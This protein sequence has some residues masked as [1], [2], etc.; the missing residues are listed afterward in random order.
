[1]KIVYCVSGTYNSGGIERVIMTKANYLAEVMGYEVI[2]ITSQQRER[3]SFYSFSSKI[4]FYDLG[5]NYDLDLDCNLFVRLYRRW[6]KK[7]K[8][9]RLLT[10]Y[11][12]E[13]RPDISIS[14]FELSSSFLYKIED[15]SRKVLECHFCKQE[16]FIASSNFFINSLQYIR[17]FYGRNRLASHYD[18]FVVLTEEDKSA[19]G[20]LSNIRVIPNA[21]TNIPY[22]KAA[23]KNKYVLSIG[24]ISYQKGFDRLISAWALVAPNFPDWKLIIRGNGDSNDLL[25]LV[26]KLGISESVEIKPATSQIADEYL[27]SSVYVMSSRYEGFGMV[28]VE[29]MSYGLPVVSFDCPCGP[30]ELISSEYGS[31]VPNGNIN[32]LASALMRWMR[33]ESGRRIAGAR[34][35]EAA[36]QYVQDKVMDKWVA[37]FEVLLS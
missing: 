27:K 2:I 35:R 9:K 33:D 15:G 4:K 25:R 12:T 28:L 30:K 5:L 20:N 8:H 36:S 13:I 24:R 29:A 1:M 21:I 31:L 11:L 16:K 37:L 10:A 3:A 34:A 22:E 18:K 32:A 6:R 26:H 7:A 17:A 19:W 23:L 14:T